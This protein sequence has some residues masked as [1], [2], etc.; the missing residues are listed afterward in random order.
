[1]H[2]Q[3]GDL[4]QAP[5]H[6]IIHGPL[7]RPSPFVH[8]TSPAATISFGPYTSVQVNVDLAGANILD[9]AANEPSIAVDPTNPSRMAIGWRQFDTVQSTFREAGYGYTTDGGL[10]WHAGKVDPGVFHSDPV[11]DF[12]AQG[13]FFYMAATIDFTIGQIVTQLF[14]STDQGATWGPPVPAFGGDKEWMAI[15]RTQGPGRGYIYETWADPGFSR[16]VDGGQSFQTPISV[17]PSPIFGTLDVGADG[18]VYLIGASFDLNSFSVSRSTNA[19]I[20]AQTP[21]FTTVPVNL[22]GAM[23]FPGNNGAPNYDGLFGQ[24]WIVADPRISQMNRVYALCSVKTPTDPMDV[25]FVRS[26]DGGQTWSSPVRVNDD[27]GH[28]AYQWFGTM[29]VAPDG[30]IDAVWNDTRGSGD[31]TKSALFYAYSNDGGLTWSPNVQVSPVWD[32]SLG[33]HPATKIGDYYHMISSDSGA[34]LAWAATFNGE[35]D[36]YYLRI[37]AP[38]GMAQGTASSTRTAADRGATDPR[39]VGNSPNPFAASTTIQFDMPG[40]GGRAKVEVFDAGGRRVTTLLD[41]FVKAGSQNV[42]WTGADDAGRPVNSGVYVCRVETAGTSKTLK[43][44]LMR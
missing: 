28:R 43:L 35:Q 4:E 21:T 16:S 36:V 23:V 1:V 14:A 39:L 31:K 29:S 27:P 18:T 37:P 22:G 2:S 33:W 34:D 41:G 11:L 38:S 3:A 25:M 30:R 7:T 17:P 24:P 44:M 19:K 32:S 13:K 5:R 20:A 26:T 8:S 12:D 15:D 9:D 40:S 6:E 42:R 10:T